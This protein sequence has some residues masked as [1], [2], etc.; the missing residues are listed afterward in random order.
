ML[1]TGNVRPDASGTG[2]CSPDCRP[3]HQ[4]DRRHR[5]ALRSACSLSALRHLKL[6]PCML[7]LRLALLAQGRQWKPTCSPIVRRGDRPVT[8]PPPS[9]SRRR[10]RRSS[11]SSR[12]TILNSPDAVA[13][14]VPRCLPDFITRPAPVSASP[15]AGTPHRNRSVPPPVAQ[16][17]KPG[18][19]ALR[20]CRI[21]PRPSPYS[22]HT[23][24]AQAISPS[25]CVTR[26]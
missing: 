10:A 3:A 4:G 20:P 1:R 23:G 25:R 5:W 22:T 13:G 16:L 14:P 8:D 11:S 12:D 18:L 21:T 9:P 17:C 2:K 15:F 7:P 24:L 19:D 6:R 26:R